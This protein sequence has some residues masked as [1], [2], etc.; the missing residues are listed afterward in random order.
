MSEEKGDKVE[1]KEGM[2][3]SIGRIVH[4]TTGDG[5]LLPAMV[6]AVKKGSA[7][8]LHVFQDGE[9]H[10]AVSLPSYCAVNVPFSEE[11]DPNTYKWPTRV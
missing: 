7:V 4:Y 9:A 3:P 11:G 6:T 5:V 1:K 8:N 10:R 2:K